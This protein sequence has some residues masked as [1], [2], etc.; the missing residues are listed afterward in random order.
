VTIVAHYKTTDH[1][2]TAATD[3]GGSASD[4][5]SI[6]RPTIG[7]TVVVDVA[8]GSAHCSTSFTPQ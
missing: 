8:V 3:G 2:F 1:T 6:G 4:T 5:F 7:Y